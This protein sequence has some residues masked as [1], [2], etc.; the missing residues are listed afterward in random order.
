[1]DTARL[2][3]RKDT[4]QSGIISLIAAAVALSSGLLAT[5]SH[6][7]STAARAPATA[8]VAA[9][10]GQAPGPGV[11]PCE[12]RGT[13]CPGAGTCVD[14]PNNPCE[15][16]CQDDASDSCESTRTEA[17]CTFQCLCAITKSCPSGQRWDGS[18]AVCGCRPAGDS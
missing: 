1:M 17:D 6:P 8:G 9:S 18:P 16:P 15:L 10:T 3:K 12:G 7:Q 14:D 11:V 4:T 13:E 5:C 2:P